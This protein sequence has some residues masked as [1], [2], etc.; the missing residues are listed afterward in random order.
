MEIR[1]VGVLGAGQMGLGIAQAVARAGF[2]TIMAKAT[3]GGLDAQ[4]SRVEKQLRKEVERGRLTAA[5]HG[6]LLERLRWTTHL[7]DLADVDLVIESIVEEAP[8]KRD[9]FARLDDIVQGEAI[10]ATNT[11]TLTVGDL[12][13]ST[14]RPEKFLGLHFFNPVHAMKLV[15][16]A[17]S[18]RTAPETVD[19]CVGFTKKLGKTPV[20]VADS[21][22]YIVNR[23]LVPFIVDA[24]GCLER[25][26][27]S[28]ADIDTAMQCGANHPMG[29]LALADFIGLDIVFHMA[30]LLQDEYKESR[31]APP[32]LL[33]R[34]V[35][36]GWLGRKTGLGFYDYRTNPPV[37]NDALAA[38]R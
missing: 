28:I 23:I 31:F 32:P 1:T 25:G 37:P 21:T 26:L 19:T 36:A 14:R 8:V 6:A 2:E 24:I 34:L 15:E 5:D 38:R 7:H 16:V 11:S 13:C 17:P 33:R 27:G 29:P 35:L 12:A 9:H 22:G 20:V 3:P 30:S 4:R 18:L 10:F